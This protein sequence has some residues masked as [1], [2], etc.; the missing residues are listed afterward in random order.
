MRQ[1]I[2]FY[3]K[4]CSC[5]G[6]GSQCHHVAHALSRGVAKEGG[7]AAA[8]RQDQ[9]IYSRLMAL[10]GDYLCIY[11]INPEDDSYIEFQG[12][13]EFGSLGISKNGKDFFADTQQNAEHA[14][15]EEDREEFKRRH[16]KEYIMKDIEKDGEFISSHHL[17]IND[18][19]VKVALR[20][21]L[22]KENGDNRLIMGI[23]KV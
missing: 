8:A 22:S 10:S 18:K 12:S 14:V 17:L 5:S 3:A 20:C 4:S 2:L 16:T 23:R 6:S 1:N 11:V 9:I 21:V 19:P 7:R 15:A 13:N